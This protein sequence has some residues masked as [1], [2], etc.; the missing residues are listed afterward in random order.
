MHFPSIRR[1]TE[2]GKRSTTVNS[3]SG[4]CGAGVYSCVTRS[5]RRNLCLSMTVVDQPLQSNRGPPTWHKG[6]RPGIGR[7]SSV[8][9]LPATCSPASLRSS[10]SL[11][12]GT[13]TF[14]MTHPRSLAYH[15]SAIFIGRPILA[16]LISNTTPHLTFSLAPTS[17]VAAYIHRRLCA[18]HVLIHVSKA[19]TVNLEVA[20]PLLIYISRL[21]YR[22]CLPGISFLRYPESPCD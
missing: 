9:P 2:I 10:L 19:W 7:N 22:L 6:S 11:P 5:I 1:A 15:V 14:C 12:R 18:V 4:Y 21:K 20:V 16:A 13:S 17:S 3:S 8:R